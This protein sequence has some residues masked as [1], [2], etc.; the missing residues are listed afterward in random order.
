M[1]LKPHLDLRWGSSQFLLNLSGG[2]WVQLYSLNTVM[3]FVD[4]EENHATKVVKEPCFTM[5]A[6]YEN[7]NDQDSD[8]VSTQSNKVQVDCR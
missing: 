5:V 1:I 4:Q 7:L 8:Q 6:N 2:I 3:C